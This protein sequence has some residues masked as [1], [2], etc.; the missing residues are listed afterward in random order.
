MSKEINLHTVNY[1]YKLPNMTKGMTDKD[2]IRKVYDKN[3]KRIESILTMQNKYGALE[4]VI[5]GRMRH[6]KINVQQATAQ[7]LRSRNM[8]TKAEQMK[9]N[10]INGLKS[11]GMLEAFMQLAEDDDPVAEKFQYH[12]NNT[13]IYDGKVLIDVSNSPAQIN[14]SLM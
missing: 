7:I 5:L 11:T 9:A 2:Y 8:T 1:I 14:L 13:Y 10:I 6:D 4:G 12:G 3:K